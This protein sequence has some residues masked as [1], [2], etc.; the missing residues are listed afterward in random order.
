MN[1]KFNRQDKDFVASKKDKTKV[2]KKSV[3]GKISNEDIEL[4][5]KCFLKKR[6]EIEWFVQNLALSKN[7][8]FRINLEANTRLGM[9]TLVR[10]IGL[11]GKQGLLY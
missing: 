5:T 2:G 9:C 7:E 1:N 3:K 4:D 8:V 10:F 11:L 6:G